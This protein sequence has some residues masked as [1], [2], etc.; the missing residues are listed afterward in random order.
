MLVD[1]HN[2]VLEI[3]KEVNGITENSLTQDWLDFEKVIRRW[4]D[5]TLEEKNMNFSE[6]TSYELNFFIMR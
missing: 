5:M 4:I 3:L 2:K 1:D 6:Y